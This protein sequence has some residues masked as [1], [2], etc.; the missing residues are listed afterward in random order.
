MES[1]AARAG[2]RFA[3]EAFIDRAYRADGTLAP[4][5]QPGAVIAD[6][7]EVARRAV[8]VARAGQVPTADGGTLAVRADTLCLHGDEPGV[9]ARARAV[10]AALAAAGVALRPIGEGPWP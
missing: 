10:R 1:A 9:A 8:E 7:A 6:P 4:R 3:A 2:L 5:S